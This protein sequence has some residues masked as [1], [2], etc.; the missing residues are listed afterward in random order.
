MYG[1]HFAVAAAAATAL[2]SF[3]HRPRLRK[4]VDPFGIKFQTCSFT[5]S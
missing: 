1:M 2:G 3:I 5:F 4:F